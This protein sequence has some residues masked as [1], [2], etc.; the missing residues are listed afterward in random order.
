MLGSEHLSLWRPTSLEDDWCALGRRVRGAI[1]S[2]LVVLAV[3]EDLVDFIRIVSSF[4]LLPGLR[5]VF[6]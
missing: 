6:P 4:W 1:R 5:S 2:R 3:G